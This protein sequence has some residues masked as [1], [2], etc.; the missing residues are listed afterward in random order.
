MEEDTEDSILGINDTPA[1]DLFQN[2][3]M[4]ICWDNCG[5]K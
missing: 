5:H 2:L 4:L 3:K 1:Y